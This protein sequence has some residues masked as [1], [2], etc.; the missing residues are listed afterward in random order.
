MSYVADPFEE[1]GWRAHRKTVSVI[2][3]RI[4]MQANHRALLGL[5]ASA[6]DGLRAHQLGEAQR[7]R[8]ILKCAGGIG[9]PCWRTPP[10]PRLASGDSFLMSSFDAANFALIAPQA[11]TAL[12]HVSPQALRFP[13][14]LRYELIEFAGLTLAARAQQLIPLH[15]AC[16]ARRSQ[17]ILLLGD[18]G[19]GKSTLCLAAGLEGFELLS[20]DSVFV[21]PN[22]LLATGIANFLHLGRDG[23]KFVDDAGAR[24]ALDAAPTIRRRSGVRKLEFDLRAGVLPVARRAAPIRIVVVLSRR[25]AR[26]NAA[27]QPL[28]RSAMLRALRSTQPYGRT[29][30]GWQTFERNLARV[31]AYVLERCEHP[32]DGVAALRTLL[33]GA[34]D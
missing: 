17:G 1:L 28:S 2:G 22:Q 13:Y 14:H 34:R 10:L 12:V 33:R 25:C 27:L 9:D 6:F 24:R 18:S 5:A 29:R 8:L 21:R 20:E 3:A 19:A 16:I 26:T 23:L 32:R 4:D 15:A 30:P 7:L 31:P 11:K